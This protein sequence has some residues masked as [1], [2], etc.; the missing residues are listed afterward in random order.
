MN[1]SDLVIA[2]MLIT[3]NEIEEFIKNRMAARGH[4]YVVTR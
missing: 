1:F 2:T 3:K 4:F